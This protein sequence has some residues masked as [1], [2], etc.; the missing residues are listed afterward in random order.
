MRDCALHHYDMR[1][2]YEDGSR[3]EDRGGGEAD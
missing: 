1:S 3:E 2:S